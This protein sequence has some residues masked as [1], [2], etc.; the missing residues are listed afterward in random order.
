ME[1]SLL[2]FLLALILLSV[3]GFFGC[4]RALKKP[5]E[6]ELRPFISEVQHPAWAEKAV[7]YEVNV[8]QFTE[9]GSFEALTTHLPRLKDLGVDI[10][11]LMPIHPIGELNRKGELGSYYSVKDYMGVN[12]EFGTMEDF[13]TFLDEA[14][15]TGFHVIIDW[16]PN[17][18]AW[19]NPLLEE[20]PD[21]YDKDS[22]G[23]FVSPYDW[24]DVVQLDWQN[25]ELQDYMLGAL[26]FWVRM[27]VDGFRVD[28]PHKTPVEFWEK[29]RAEMEKIR[30]VFLLAENEDQTGFLE[31]GFDMNYSWEL[32]HIMNRVAQGKDSVRSIDRYFKR[33][34]RV[35]PQNALRLRFID[36]HDEN[37]WAGTI[38]ERMAGAHRAFAVFMFTIPGMP[39][40]YNGQEACLDKRLEFFERDPIEW[41]EYDMTEFYKDLI[42]LKKENQALWNGESGGLMVRIKSGKDRKIFSFFREKD[43][44]R[45]VVFLNLSK[46][47]RRFKPVVEDLEGEYLEVFS[48]DTF[49]FPLTDSLRLEAW[50]YMVFTAL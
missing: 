14:R 48:G 3:A 39:L 12:P 21:W 20:H 27:G 26:L 36:N 5:S 49:H 38:E 4:R 50:D 33:E 44:N 19:D 8:R 7:I 31:K 41:G 10:L 47:P 2:F 42:R 35:Y 16:V 43:N 22:T 45:V 34:Q 18:T 40:L 32:H 6:K 9:E 17:H 24:T 28:H 25:E 23:A 30:P 37:S 29:A 46:K 1:K 11:W 15:E 13:K